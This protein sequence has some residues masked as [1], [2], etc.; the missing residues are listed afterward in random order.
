MRPQAIDKTC[1][2]YRIHWIIRHVLKL[3]LLTINKQLCDNT[4]ALIQM[5]HQVNG[6]KNIVFIIF[7]LR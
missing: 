2:G 6:E 5:T 7:I 1:I 3:I 4:E